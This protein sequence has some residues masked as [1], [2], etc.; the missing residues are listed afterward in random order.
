MKLKLVAHLADVT[1]LGDELVTDLDPGLNH[2]LEHV[3]AVDSQ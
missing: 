3:C 1:T 2:V